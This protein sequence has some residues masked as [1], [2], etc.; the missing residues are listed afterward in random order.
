M[1]RE[2]FELERRFITNINNLLISSVNEDEDEFYIHGIFTALKRSAETA[3][4]EF[5]KE[6][7]NASDATDEEREQTATMI[8]LCLCSRIDFDFAEPIIF[9][10][11]PSF[12]LKHKYEYLRSKLHEEMRKAKYTPKTHRSPLSA[13]DPEELWKISRLQDQIGIHYF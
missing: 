9:F 4:E 10:N 11:H 13:A 6:V 1:E 8:V 12:D 5:E 7:I 2:P 3:S